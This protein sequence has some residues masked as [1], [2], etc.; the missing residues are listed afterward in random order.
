MAYVYIELTQERLARELLA[1]EYAGWTNQGAYALAE[2][3]IELAESTDE[4]IKFDRVA[5]RCEFSEYEDLQEYNELYGTEHCCPSDI[6]YLAC[7]VN[8]SR[9]ICYEH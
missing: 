7:M 9:F 5:I 1:D 8:G 6:D 3:L 4:P 2:Y